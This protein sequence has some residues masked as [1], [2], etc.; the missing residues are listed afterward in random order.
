LPTERGV[1]LIP[2]S[3]H[4]PIF[5]APL[6]K[7]TTVGVS[8][9][10]D[11]V[12]GAYHPHLD[13]CL[14]NLRS[15]GYKV[16][17]GDCLRDSHEGVSAPREDRAREL[18][19]MFDNSNISAII[20]P[21]GGEMFIDTL[22]LIDFAKIKSS[23]NKWVMGYSDTSTFL[24]AKTLV[25][26]VATAHGPCLMDMGTIGDNHPLTSWTDI[27]NSEI[28]SQIV[29]KS[30]PRC[31]TVW[32]DM[33]KGPGSPLLFDKET[34]W[35][36]FYQGNDIQHLELKGRLIGGCLETLRNLVGTPYGDFNKLKKKW[37]NEGV[38]FYLESAGDLPSTVYRNLW[39]LKMAGWFEGIK[40]VVLGRFPKMTYPEDSYIR[41]VLSVFKEC[42]IPLIYDADIGHVPPQMVFI[43]GA[44]SQINFNDGDATVVQNLG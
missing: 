21:W 34:H 13:K 20:P 8:A 22:P 11:G 16:I 19:A 42:E 44:Y 17:E 7:G 2:T 24:F 36:A 4:Q 18:M 5:P 12:A 31:L 41:A 35:K 43:N 28:N 33:V 27:L 32:P 38:I 14:K 1:I 39:Q 40:G 9:I 3:P 10:S 30:F 15:L 23:T 25:S 37:K 26:G 6:H 29:Q